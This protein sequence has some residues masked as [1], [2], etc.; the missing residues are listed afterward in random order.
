M[1]PTPSCSRMWYGPMVVARGGSSDCMACLNG[2]TAPRISLVGTS[3]D[4][5]SALFCGELEDIA[6]PLTGAR[7]GR[8]AGALWTDKR[9]AASRFHP[10]KPRH[11]T[12]LGSKSIAFL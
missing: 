3:G 8:W 1:P 10:P 12:A 11:P 9:P 4:A 6:Q 7:D 2:A 5:V